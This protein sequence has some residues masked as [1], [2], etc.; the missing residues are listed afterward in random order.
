MD[1]ST[2]RP[3]LHRAAVWAVLAAV[4]LLFAG[5]VSVNRPAHCRS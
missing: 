4:Y 1:Q 5:S 3:I 2:G